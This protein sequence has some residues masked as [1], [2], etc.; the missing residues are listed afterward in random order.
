MCKSYRCLYRLLRLIFRQGNHNFLGVQSSSSFV[1]T[2]KQFHIV[3]G[4]G[5]VAGDVIT[6]NISIAGLQLNA[7][8]FGVASAESIDFSDNS[9]PFDGL[10]GLA[11]SVRLFSFHCCT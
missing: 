5:E 6:D 11:Q 2:N 4:T 3:Y 1:D 7:H 10:M 8:V 9:I